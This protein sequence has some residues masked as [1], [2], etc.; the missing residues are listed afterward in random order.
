MNKKLKKCKYCNKYYPENDF[1]IA[2]TIKDRVYRRKKCRDCYRK[3]KKELQQK[4][5]LW[6][7]K[8]KTEKK[9]CKC[10]IDDYRVLEFHHKNGSEKEFSVGEISTKGYGLKKIEKELKKCLVICANCHRK[11]HYQIK[12]RI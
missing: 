2:L 12:N 1:G 7:D 9:C 5:R 10:G 6:I 3:T 4:Y 8:Y 11:F